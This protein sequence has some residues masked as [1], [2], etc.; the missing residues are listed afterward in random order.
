METGANLRH[1]TAQ[2]IERL[3]DERPASSPPGAATGHLASCARCRERVDALRA[4]VTRL[5]S[6]GRHGPVAG[7]ADAVA[8][9]INLMDSVLDRELE[10][11]PAWAP[12]PAFARDIMAQVDLPHP[13]VDRA[14][15]R[16]SRWA[17]APGFASSVLARVRLPVPWPERLLRLVRRRR[18]ALATAGVATLSISGGAAAWLFGTQ[19]FTPGYILALAVGGA[20]TLLVDAMLAAG[21]LGYRLGLVD[22]GGSIVDRVDPAAALASLVLSS[23]VGLA[24]LW[25]VA[26]LFRRPARQPIRL[27]RAA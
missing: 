15:S 6:L 4:L 23:L 1:L 9:R 20:R 13:A 24:S 11:L 5:G 22:A 10:R 8:R 21:R 7:F 14:L 19:G 27:R 12:S 25:V 3:A 17:P 26:S 16:L 18:A 2:E